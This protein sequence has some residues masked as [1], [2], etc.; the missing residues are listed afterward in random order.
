M[1]GYQPVLCNWKQNFDGEGRL[2]EEE[3]EPK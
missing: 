3:K 2:V 1:D